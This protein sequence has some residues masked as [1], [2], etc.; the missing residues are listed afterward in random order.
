MVEKS[1]LGMAAGFRGSVARIGGPMHTTR[2]PCRPPEGALMTL[3]VKT[4]GQLAPLC[5]TDQAHNKQ[6]STE[7]NA[8]AEIFRP[9]CM[10]KL[11][12]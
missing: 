12:Q 5:S 3:F 7:E 6:W 1:R 4:T 10:T 2:V 11:H 8:A 9:S